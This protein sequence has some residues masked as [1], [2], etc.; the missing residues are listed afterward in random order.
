MSKRTHT[1]QDQSTTE[2]R[3]LGPEFDKHIAELRTKS[4]YEKN[5]YL[6]EIKSKVIDAQQTLDKKMVD[7]EYDIQR[8]K[9]LLRELKEKRNLFEY[10]RELDNY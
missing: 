10:F 4:K 7:V 1:E 2:D 5:R 6:N 9:M 3:V 8:L